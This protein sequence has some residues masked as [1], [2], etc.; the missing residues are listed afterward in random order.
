[1]NMY[2]NTNRIKAINIGPMQELSKQKLDKNYTKV[3]TTVVLI[4]GTFLYR[5]PISL[6]M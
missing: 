3:H 5:N 2:I 4:L 6:Q 1:M